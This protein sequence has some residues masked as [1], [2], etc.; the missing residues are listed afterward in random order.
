MKTSL[1]IIEN[2]YSNPYEVREFALKQEYET[3]PYSP[4]GRT[5]QSFLTTTTKTCLEQ[6]ILPHAGKITFFSLDCGCFN[7]TI[8]NS[9]SEWKSGQVHT[10][11]VFDWAG[12]CY[13]TPDAPAG[14]GTSILLN[15]KVKTLNLENRKLQEKIG[16]DWQDLTKWEVHDIV[17]NKFNRLVLY[18]GQLAHAPML[19]FGN[20]IHTGRLTQVFFFKTEH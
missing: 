16:N 8:A 1:I 5:K 19:H 18:R 17:G 10:D 11:S 2:F 14:T 12:L 4:G 20:D 7:Y 9:I 3:K 6:L 13:L 15:K